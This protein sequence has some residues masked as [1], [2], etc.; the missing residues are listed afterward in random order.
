M[1]SLPSDHP[2]SVFLSIAR[3]ISLFTCAVGVLVLIGWIFSEET[4]KSMH[5]DWI[6]MRANTAICF[7]L[8]GASL[9]LRL[10]HSRGTPPAWLSQGLALLVF[11]AG[12]LTFL[13]YTL[14]FDFR[15]DQALFRESVRAASTE[16]PGRMSVTSAA[17]FILLGW[18]LFFF[19]N[20]YGRLMQIPAVLAAC[21]G[22]LSVTGYLYGAQDLKQIGPQ[23]IALHTAL[24]FVIFSVGLVLGQ[25]DAGFMKLVTR[26]EVGG[27]LMR[28][29]LPAMLVVPFVV[30]WLML[31]GEH[32]GL[33]SPETAWALFALTTAMALAGTVGRSATILNGLDESLRESKA[34]L[35]AEQALKESTARYRTLFENMLDGYA[36][37]RMLY[38]GEEPCDFVYLEVNSTFKRLTGLTNV[39][40]KKATEVIPGIRETN[41]ELFVAYGKVARTGVPER[42]EA[43]LD[44]LKTWLF[45]SVY[46]PAPDH[47]IAI[48]E[49]IN[50]RRNLGRSLEQQQN[51]LRTV[52]DSLPDLIFVKDTQGKFVLANKALASAA[53]T[54]DPQSLVGKSDYDISPKEIADL[55][56]ANDRIV[57][58][59]ARSQIN[60]E[61]LSTFGNASARWILTTKVPLIDQE[62]AV[63]GLVGISRDIT[64]RRELETNM[65]QTQK[66]ESLGVLA[67]GIAH[68]FNNIL[69]VILGNA[70]AAALSVPPGS[71]A[72]RPLEEIRKAS[73][74]AADL[75]RQ[76]LAYSGKGRFE[77]RPLDVSDVIDEMLEMLNI[78]ISKKATLHLALARDLPSVEADVA[79][80][81]QVVMNLIMNASEAI[82]DA[83]G[84]ITVV[85]AA[86]D[87][88]Q[89]CLETGWAG[90]TRAPGRYV[91]LEVTDTGS[92]MDE[93]TRARMFE[94]FFTTK[95]TGR[96][97]GLSAVMGIVRGHKGAIRVSSEPGQGTKFKLLF[98]ASSAAP[99]KLNLPRRES[100]NMAGHGMILVVDD[101]EGI[102][103]IA[104][105]ILERL[106]FTVLT[107]ADGSEALEV[108]KAHTAEIACVM[109]DLTMPKMDGEK[110]FRLMRLANP[111]VKV[112]LC[113]GY[114]EQQAVRQFVGGGLSG[115]MQKPY[116]QETLAQK[117]GEI[118]GMQVVGGGKYAGKDRAE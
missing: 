30:G 25:P 12:V 43:Y 97:L 66:L 21:L 106:G 38:Q 50:E 102:L 104:R 29:L 71:S 118:L 69:T 35:R 22:I 34:T 45:V 36:Y 59:S 108:Y 91:T 84:D 23:F 99:Q 70:E 90:E 65:Q 117:L 6:S 77:V 57:V 39:E 74:R 1:S 63:S 78:G 80:I 14:G 101:D 93:M 94:P 92:G 26:T 48:F 103:V 10:R 11:L 67:G 18:S 9:W 79:Q 51:L 83:G 20:R 8:S 2:A 73:Q 32:L 17:N 113:S 96:G 75:C 87:C 47:F 56:V 27:I 58:D 46:S 86:A 88:D 107:A 72:R 44:S 40:G 89:S 53:G 82:G 61:E 114:S 4:L 16:I 62:G 19:G 95:F 31:T 15:I 42:L 5:P 85:T 13:E 37:C 24:T 110:T 100:T 55:Y 76:M 111:E 68:D 7:I 54:A 52:I 3:S 98:P 28:R 41:P 112:L 33:Y 109:L 81:R 115:F 60:T 64:E 105:S 49:N 116:L